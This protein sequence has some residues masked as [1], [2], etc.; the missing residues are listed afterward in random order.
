MKRDN[1]NTFNSPGPNSCSLCFLIARF[2]IMMDIRQKT[3]FSLRYLYHCILSQHQETK[4]SSN[5]SHY[6]LIFLKQRFV[7]VVSCA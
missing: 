1:G 5:F 7:G 2:P 4:T 6:R 3:C